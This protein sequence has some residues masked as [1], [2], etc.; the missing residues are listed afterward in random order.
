[1]DVSSLML[2][3]TPDDEIGHHGDN[4]TRENDHTYYINKA[5][6][7]NRQSADIITTTEIVKGITRISSDAFRIFIL[8]FNRLFF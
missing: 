2:V 5:S 1:M 3:D 6:V 8:K 4:H 7:K